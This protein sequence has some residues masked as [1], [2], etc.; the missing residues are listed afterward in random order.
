MVTPLMKG[1]EEVLDLKN[2]F[3]TALDNNPACRARN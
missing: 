3:Q 2:K 1:D